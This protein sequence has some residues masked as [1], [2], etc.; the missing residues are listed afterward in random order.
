MHSIDPKQDRP[1]RHLPSM[2][3]GA[4]IPALL[5]SAFFISLL[6]CVKGALG[7]GFNGAEGERIGLH[8][9]EQSAQYQ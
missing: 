7:S 4:P 2:F 8:L 5:F 3:I 1:A 9:S 6:M